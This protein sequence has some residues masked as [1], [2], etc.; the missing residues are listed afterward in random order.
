[1]SKIENTQKQRGS[2]VTKSNRPNYYNTPFR[3]KQIKD[4]LE[5]LT[6]YVRLIKNR[7]PNR[8]EKS[9]F[10]SLGLPMERENN[11]VK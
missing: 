9:S 1:M 6:T 8:D 5:C 11:K 7:A 3:S 10:I 2:N 4:A